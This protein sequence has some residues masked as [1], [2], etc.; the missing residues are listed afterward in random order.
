[1]KAL[2]VNGSPRK[3]WNTHRMLESAR[4]SDAIIIGAPV[5]YGYASAQCRAFLERLMF[6]AGT[7]LVDGDGKAVRKFT[8]VIPTAMIYTMNCPES[9]AE[10]VHYPVLLGINVEY[11]RDIFGYS[12]MLCA[13]DTYQFSDY[14]RYAMNLFREED[15]AKWRDEHF[16]EDVR[17]AY[18]LGKRLTEKAKFQEGE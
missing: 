3:G 10:K 4:M 18:E 17:K 14:S 6:A 5:Y 9:L 12:E 11:L 1:M 16:P 13:Y 15:K 8:R 7:Y 2:F